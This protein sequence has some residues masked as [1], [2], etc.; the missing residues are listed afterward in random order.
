MSKFALK[1]ENRLIAVE[2]CKNLLCSGVRPLRSKWRP[3]LRSA[4]N[5][6][7][8]REVCHSII[9]FEKILEPPNTTL[10]CEEMSLD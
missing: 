1:K 5:F 2:I 4:R 9:Q 6:A 8:V 10:W 7:L 3:D